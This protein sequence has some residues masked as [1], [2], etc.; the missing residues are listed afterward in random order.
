MHT[1]DLLEPRT[2]LAFSFAYAS[3]FGDIETLDSGNAVVVDAQG[4]TYFAGTFRGRIDVNRSNH[5]KHF[6]KA[7]DNY[8]AFL[9]KYDPAGKLLWSEQFGS[10][11]GDETIEHM[12]IGPN[13]DVYATGQF[14]EIVD[15][16]PK[17]GVH[18]L[19]SHGK[20]D[21][22]IL[23]LTENGNYVWAGNIG[24]EL[25]DDITAFAVGPSGDMYYSGFVRLRGDADPTRGVRSIID[26][27]VDDTIIARLNGTTGAIKWM[28]VFGEDATRETVFGLAVDANENVTAAG[29]F[30]ETVGFDRHDSSFDREAVGSDDVYLAK[31]DSRGDFQFIK[32]IGGKKQ[33]TVVDMVQDDQGNLYLTGNFAK[34]TDFEPGPGQTLLAAPSGGSAYVLKMD[35]DANLTWVRQIGPAVIG[36][37]AEQAVVIARSIGI[38]VNGAVSTVGDFAG[39]VD[40]D[41]GSG[42]RIID[43]DKSGNTPALP[44]QLLPSDTYVH[45]L[46]SDGNFLA[47]RHF[48]GEDGTTLA[49]DIAVDAAGAINITGAYAGFVDLNPTSGAFRRSTHE[50]RGDSNVFLV[51][52]LP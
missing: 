12:V 14:E 17:A 15:F 6:L 46:D 52:L 10:A 25:D 9:V 27:G 20:R 24:G 5:R 7:D 19:T 13:G 16:D 42:Q 38:D 1:I 4:N 21:A 43:V 47:V 51:K 28:K 11:D 8:D 39:T 33:E 31:L 2:L 26:R 40:F 37:D 3:A 49:H 34:T 22:F 29:M 44:G 36:G 30:N 45:K 32:T 23:H 50:H 41:P 18:R 35:A 48:G